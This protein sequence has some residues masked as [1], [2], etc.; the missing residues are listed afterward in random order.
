MSRL[1][2]LALFPLDDFVVAFSD[3]AQQLLSLNATAA[4]VIRELQKGRSPAEAAAL[5]ASSGETEPEQAARWVDALLGVLGAHG[6]IDDGPVRLAAPAPAPP[7]NDAE[8]APY[9]PVAAAVE[10]SYRLLGTT[11]LVR[12]ASRAQVRLVNSVLGHLAVP[13]AGRPDVVIEISAAFTDPHN[14]KSDVYRDGVPVGHARRL[15]RLAPIVKIAL[16]QAAVHAHEHLFNIHAGVVG[17]ESACIL[18]PAAAGSG[19]TSLTVA[20]VQHGFRY[21]SDEVALIEPAGFRVPPVPLAM[22]IKSTGWDVIAR[23]RP[24]IAELPIHMRTDGKVLRY[25]PPPPGA[26][27]QPPAPVSHVIFPRFEPEAPTR[28]EPVSRA[29]ALGRLFN[30]CQSVPCRLDA[31]KV[32]EVVRWIGAVACFDLS[33]SSL[34]RAV[35]LIAGATGFPGA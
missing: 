9:A 17:T 3:E 5:L 15:S 23:Y 35:E 4:L 33:F 34:D 20:L 26:T 7:P 1:R 12:F 18:L 24:E 11:A 10:Q 16:W 2:P 21:F 29:E 25:L 27:R 32:D 14:I 19:K 22:A 8:V 13:T 28:L 31:G 6:M 30:E